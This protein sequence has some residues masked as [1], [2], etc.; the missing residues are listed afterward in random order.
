MT[1]TR[2]RP[3]AFLLLWFFGFFGAVGWAQAAVLPRTDKLI[4]PET[5]LLIEVDDFSRLKGQFEKTNF[6]KLYKD[7]S[8]AAFVEDFK[9]KLSE[10]V[11]KLNNKIAEATVNVGVLPEGRVAIAWVLDEK[12]KEKEEPSS[13]FIVQWG[14]MAAKIEEAVE[15]QVKKAVEDGA[16]KKIEDYRGITIVTI[17]KELPPK[18]VPD[19]GSYNPEGTNSPAMK[20]V[21]PPPEKMHYCFAD[22]NLVA[23]DNIDVLKF[24]I[25]HIKGATGA[26]L[27]DDSDYAATTRAVGPYH[28]IDF[29][30]NIKQIIRTALAQDATSKTKT[31]ISNLGLD[32]VTSLGCSIGISRE[33]GGSCSGKALLRIAGRKK[34]LCKM[35]DFEPAVPRPPQFVPSSACSAIFLNLNLGKAYDELANILKSFSAQAATVMFM[36]LLPPSPE[37][38]G[39]LELKRDIIDHLGSQVAIAQSVNKPVSATLPSV[40]TVFALAVNNRKALEKSLSLLHSRVIA[41]NNPDARRELLGHTIYL[42]TVPGLPFLRPG[43]TPMQGPAGAGALQPP[44][45]AFTVTDTHLVFGV[46]STVERAIRALSSTQAA[47][48]GSAKWFTLSR[49]AIP[50]VVGLASLQDDAAASELSWRMMKESAKGKSDSTDSS[51]SMGVGIGSDFGLIFSQAGLDLFN[52]RLLPEFEAVRKYFGL[53]VSYGVS[54]P[55]GFFF[56]FKYLNLPVAD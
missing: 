40:E 39:G 47:S 4:P 21:Q 19:L 27:A 53:S 7:P 1:I 15:E 5:V 22:D 28:D 33:P 8:M 49:S 54:R 43:M 44:T 10:K 14:Q 31:T 30:V 50:S 3:F 9:S 26:T 35:L 6:F 18:K 12:T 56:E 23:S 20:T 32:N 38:E 2:I 51:L 37:G 55:D 11:R 52:F 42:V 25:A 46:E 34:G 41:A 45:L 36:P 17:I 13:L 24:V 16:H 48:I 29:Y